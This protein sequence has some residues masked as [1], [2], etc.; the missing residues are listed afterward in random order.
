MRTE[1]QIRIELTFELEALKAARQ[2]ADYHTL[3]GQERYLEVGYRCE[4]L[5][6]EL[7]Q[8]VEQNER[9]LMAPLVVQAA[10]FYSACQERGLSRRQVVSMLEGVMQ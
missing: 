9:D 6:F 1:D 5:E 4:K 8:L 7:R 10:A 2:A 3:H